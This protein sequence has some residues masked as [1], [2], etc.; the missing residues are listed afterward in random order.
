MVANSL[1][2]SLSLSRPFS[3]FRASDPAVEWCV[4]DPEL[5]STWH[6]SDTNQSTDRNKRAWKAM[7][8]P[9]PQ[10]FHLEEWAPEYNG[11]HY[12]YNNYYNGVVEPILVFHMCKHP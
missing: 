8:L 2:C 4:P 3:Q 10:S 9:Q 6:S 12:I 1:G 5:V 7:V 11:T